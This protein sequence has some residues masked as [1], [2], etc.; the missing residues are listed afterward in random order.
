MGLA[1]QNLVVWQRADDFFIEVH[2]LTHQRFPRHE[3]FELS[4]QLR[5]AA[6]SVPSNI[7]EGIAR[8]HRREAIRFFDIASASLS[9]LGY[10]LHASARLGYITTAELATLEEKLRLI[11]APLNGLIRRYK[12]R[13]A[14]VQGT[15]AVMLIAVASLLV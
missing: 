9:E 13:S 1:H 6:Y 5:R 12:F 7:V 14:L 15:M 2:R 8:R 11:A 3:R 10:G 4:P